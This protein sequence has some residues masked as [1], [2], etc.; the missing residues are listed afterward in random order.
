M[1]TI[2]WL[3]S[4]EEKVQTEDLGVEGRVVLT[5]IWGKYYLGYGLDSSGSR[6]GPVACFWEHNNECYGSIK[7][8]EYL[9]SAC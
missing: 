5:W 4:L 3:D 1:R 2:F 9:D 8:G 7:G 6:Y